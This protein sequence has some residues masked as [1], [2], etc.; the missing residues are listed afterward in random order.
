MDG[1]K[2]G[3]IL[4]MLYDKLNN[5]LDDLTTVKLDKSN[6]ELTFKLIFK[7]KDVK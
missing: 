7:R 6:N 2:E 3:L 4:S 1:Y 5:D